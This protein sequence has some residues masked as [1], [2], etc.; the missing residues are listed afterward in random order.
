[1][2]GFARL[3][4]PLVALA[5]EPCRMP[6]AGRPVGFDD[7]GV[8]AVLGT[9]RLGAAE[10]AVRAAR[11]GEAVTVAVVTDAPAERRTGTHEG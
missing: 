6:R 7:D 8:I 11:P 5:L 1:M 2:A 4:G 3:D 10:E 9:G